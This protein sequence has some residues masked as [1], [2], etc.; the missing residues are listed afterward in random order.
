[1]KQKIIN[2]LGISD[3]FEINLGNLKKLHTWGTNSNSFKEV[4]T[5]YKP[6][7]ILEIG[8]WFGWSAITMAQLLKDQKID[9]CIVCVDTFTGSHEHWADP[10]HYPTLNCKGGRPTIYES[11][12]SNVRSYNLEKYILPIPI[13][14]SAAFEFFYRKNFKVD[15][16]YID[17]DHREHA[18]YQDLIDSKRTLNPEGFILGDD[19][20]WG[21]VQDGIAMFTKETGISYDKIHNKYYIKP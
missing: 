13:T 21:T 19:L 2:Q 9:G 1:M 14:S 18:V 4:I 20:D 5:K 6:K 11:F 15:M 12:M 16:I 3:P 10:N 7:I 8:T 17:G